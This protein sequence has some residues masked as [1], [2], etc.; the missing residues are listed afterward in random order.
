MSRDGRAS[1]VSKISQVQTLN[2]FVEVV[3]KE[4]G[5]KQR[6]CSSEALHYEVFRNDNVFYKTDVIL[7][8]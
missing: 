8:D 2:I 5:E 3:Q 1:N 7:N 6:E 4:K